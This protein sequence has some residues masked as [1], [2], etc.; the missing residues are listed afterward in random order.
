MLE[1]RVGPTAREW[2]VAAPPGV[3]Y[4]L[5]ADTVR[6]PLFLTSPVHVE[7]LEPPGGGPAEGEGPGRT[8]EWLRM[9]EATGGGRVRSWSAVRH[10]DAARRR[11]EFR[12]APGD[13]ARPGGDTWTVD[14]LGARHSKLTLLRDG[15]A[16]APEAT[17]LRHPAE[18]WERLD[19][20]V[21]S[22]EESVRADGPAAAV[23]DVLHRAADWPRLIPHVVAADLTERTPG[24]QLLTLR[25]RDPDGRTRTT[26]S[27]RICSPATGRIVHK[28]TVP[29]GLIA[30]HTCEWSVRSA[31]RG[32][33]VTARHRV[34]L[35]EERIEAVLGAGTDTAAARRRVRD[36]LGRE[37]AAL[38]H[39]ARRQA[40][41][42]GRAGPG[43][44]RTA[45]RTSGNRTAP[46]TVDQA[47]PAERAARLEALLGDPFDAANPHGHLA[48]LRADDRREV[49]GATEAL[50]TEERLGTEFVPRELGG[51]LTDLEG[52]ARVMRPVFRRD[53]GLAYGFGI[54]SLFAATA[55]W[56]A[57]DD[58]QREET[59]RLMLD[60]GRVSIVHRDLAHAN[61]ILRDE[62]SA[63]P[64]AG[65]FVLRGRKHVVINADRAD[66][67]VVYARTAPPAG[68]RSHSVLLVPDRPG[69]EMLRRL[70]RVE[71]A[72][73]RG[74]RFAGL[75]PSGRTVPGDAL[76]GA[77]GD[78]ISL[79]LR[80]FQVSHSLI[81][82]TA[83]ASVDSV[84]RQAVRAATEE[85]AA[86][87]PA[88]RWHGV[89]AGVF[90]DLLACDSM[91]V[92]GLRALSLV[93]RS[94][95]LLG[96]AV[97]YTVPDLLR[98]DLE[99][100]ATVLGA[101]GYERGPL[102]GSFQKTVRDLAVAGLGHAG[103]AACQAV[104][105]PRL[106]TLARGTWL[107]TEEPPDALYRPGAPLP[108]FD[109]RGLSVTGTDDLLTATVAGA[110]SRLGARRSAGP[111]HAA[112]AD[113]AAALLDELR[114]LRTECA[115]MPPHDAATPVDPRS[116]ALVDR[117][118]L[119]LAAGAG[120]GV[121]EAAAGDGS[122][123]GD[124]SWAV[125][126][127]SRIVRRLGRPVPELPPGVTGAVLAEVL[128]RY[129]SG[130]SLDL[131][132]TA[133]AG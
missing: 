26:E 28:Q 132:G 20:L 52:L 64:A 38:L 22:F 107:R 114:L 77:L 32:T 86:G 131:Y 112:L 19:D 67:F 4:G 76:V 102:Y 119:V 50:L 75:E 85:R 127:L 100:L 116:L 68:P 110:A 73:M 104:L 36:T 18:R 97:K 56:T 8:G 39:L 9:W 115:E 57:G 63:R 5:I 87:M 17:G 58:R 55:V 105:V 65:G 3:L 111:V 80:T 124:P 113:L 70:P 71:T 40:D 74:A 41:G 47:G 101:R 121:H 29:S 84:L 99:E 42:E 51:R 16:A 130:R 81:P 15:P 6:W 24:V 11:V 7:F 72:G 49:P 13:G 35:H 14:P 54:T 128:D 83:V 45:A 34:L 122:F 123:N 88:R 31:G 78:G 96:A 120:L 90:A 61:A 69:E 109:H 21:L 25:T 91:A 1:T 59:A 10:L 12:R 37:S 94:A 108:P 106:R 95:Y 60:G 98:E 126:A 82:G 30:S 46:D 133:L 118:A 125:L 129:R 92:T 66:A 2:D 23:Y 48:L 62:M 43:T 103:T 93:P 27:V 117:Y 89:L 44:A 33:T 79:S 53:I